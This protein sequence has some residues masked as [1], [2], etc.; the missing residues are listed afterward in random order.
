MSVDLSEAIKKLQRMGGI[1]QT[2]VL[3]IRTRELMQKP[4]CGVKDPVGE[5]EGGRKKRYVLAPSKWD[6][7]DLT[8][9]I[10]NYTPDLPWQE[11]RRVIADAFKVWSDVTDLTFT[12]VMNTKADIMI[13]FASKYH[14]DGYP[15]DGKGLILAHAFFPGKDKGGDTH[16]DEDE[17]WTI[18]SNGEGVDLFMVAAHEFGHALGLSHSNEPKALMYPWYQGYIPDFQLPYDDTLGIQVIYGGKGPYVTFRPPA[19]TT[20]RPNTG[21]YSTL[22][23]PRKAPID[24]CK[25]NF[26][27]IAVIRSEVFIFIGKYFWRS[28]EPKTILSSEPSTIHDF[29]YG[30]PDN[31]ES[32]DAAFEHPTN[33]RIYFFSGNRYWIYDGNSLSNGHPGS[34]KPITDFGIPQDIEKIDAVFVWGFNKRIYLISND[35]YWKFKESDE[36]IEPDYPRDMSIWKNV[37]I[38][39]DTAFKFQ[40]NTYFL[41]G[42]EMYKFYDMKMR[43]ALNWPKSIED[44]LGCGDRFSV[45]KY[46]SKN[47]PE[48]I[49]KKNSASRRGG[50]AFGSILVLVCL[51]CIGLS[52]I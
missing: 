38:P 50:S 20:R 16:F 42:K 37:P 27:A 47:S 26:D 46:D 31:V 21:G 34:G 40:D 24:P 41:K 35:M 33:R 3:D 39:V 8:Y 15:F 1:T 29:W 25:G 18:N 43:V 10:E 44:F 11:V 28:R 30:L 45:R 48:K 2:G 19:R 4:R 7:T 9:R 23:P 49:V 13:K 6:H 52:S 32:I 17:K 12:E 36:Y 5:E 22:A 14:K 51:I